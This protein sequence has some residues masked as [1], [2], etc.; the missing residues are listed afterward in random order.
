MSLRT[1]E[2]RFAGLPEYP[3]APR[4]LEVDGLRVHYVAEGPDRGPVVL[5]LHGEPTWSYL[6]RRMIPP[7]AAAGF[8]VVAPDLIGFGRSDKL[9][10]IDDY[11]YARHVGWLAAVVARL[12]LQGV[13]LFAQ[14]WGGLLG[15]RVA[16]EDPD[17]F[18]RIVVSNTFL[19]VG[20]GATEGFRRWREYARTV[21]DFQAGKIVAKGTVGGLL[22]EVQAAYD[23]P[24]PDPS[25]QAAAR[26]FPLLVPV[27]PDDP[28]VAA[29][30]A[31]WRVLEQWRKPFLTAFGDRDPV[32]AGLD[33]PFQE[34]V[35]G[36]A[37][38]PHVTV[39]GAGHFV[40]E[41]APDRLV[42]IITQFAASNP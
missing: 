23:A 35:P 30:R 36:A 24:F 10:R 21:P 37:G 33:R 7:L 26:A 9:E 40:Q 5:L 32:T 15:L 17:R 38:R 41:D 3:F 28:A 27:E 25:Y 12:E 16:M 22:P 42:G 1:P 29:N 11:S 31:A 39:T 18:A 6:Y 4:Y 20:H 2:A 34:R 19:P 8:R 14:D 13:T